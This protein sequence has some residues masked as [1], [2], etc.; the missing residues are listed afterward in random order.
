MRPRPRPRPHPPSIAP[1]RAQTQPRESRHAPR[2]ASTR[3]SPT[4]HAR[5]QPVIGCGRHGGG[6]GQRAADS[7]W[8][9]SGGGFQPSRREGQGLGGGPRRTASLLAG[10]SQQP[11]PGPALGNPRWDSGRRSRRRRRRLPS[12]SRPPPFCAAAL[13]HLRPSP[14]GVSRGPPERA[15]GPHA[16][17]LRSIYTPSP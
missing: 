8:R 3:G 5:P 13:A 6:A 1:P 9:R 10:D 7:R 11:S 17:A 15:R 4:P 16:A 12:L 14:S 2:P